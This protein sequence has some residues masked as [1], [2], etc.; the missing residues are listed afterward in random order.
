MEF[1]HPQSRKEDQHDPWYGWQGRHARHSW[2]DWLEAGQERIDIIVD[3]GASTSMLP[4]DVAKDHPLR[5]G[6][7]RLYTTASKQEVRVEGEKDLVCGFMDG[8]EFRMTWEVGDISRPLSSVSQMIQGGHRVWFDTEERGGSG[9]YSY[10]TGKTMKIYERN[11]IFV[12][13]AWIR[14]G[15]SSSSQALERPEAGFG[16]QGQH[17]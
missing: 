11:G 9:C 10:A 3:S 17:L 8:S 2:Q 1:G 16:W 12:L 7:D 13:P 15:T 6:G 4:K 5:P 14:S